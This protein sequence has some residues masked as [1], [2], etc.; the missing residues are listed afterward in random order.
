MLLFTFLL[1]GCEDEQKNEPEC[2]AMCEILKAEFERSTARI[3]F[4][5]G[6]NFH[7]SI[8]KTA[9]GAVA[10]YWLASRSIDHQKK[11]EVEISMKEWQ[12]FIFALFKC[13]IS[14]W[15]KEYDKHSS[16]SIH[17]P[18]WD[19]GGWSLSIHSLDTNYR[20]KTYRGYKKY[21]S[22]WDEFMKII[23]AMETK[24]IEKANAPIE[25]KLRAEYQRK[26]GEPISN[27]ELSTE[28]VDLKFGYE[29]LNLNVRRSETDLTIN[30]TVGPGAVLYPKY[31]LRMEFDIDEW[32]DFVRALHKLRINEWEKQY[33]EM[34]GSKERWYIQIYHTGN[35]GNPDK[36]EFYDTYPPNWDEF[37]KVIDDMVEKVKKNGVKI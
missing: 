34:L 8:T 2:D 6:E 25:A 23:D 9:T 21:P 3:A 20:P 27:F 10:L 36:F 24:I 14:E 30:K 5:Y 35:Y 11:F 13:N 18:S 28:H 22:N 17:I 1:L 16:K 33:G 31:G 37:M 32:L 12:D 15:D 7:I 26:F 29:D 4:W 19:G